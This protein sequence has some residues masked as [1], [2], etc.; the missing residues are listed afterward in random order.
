MSEGFSS[1][2]R[3]GVAEPQP[4]PKTLDAEEERKRRIRGKKNNFN[5]EEPEKKNLR[6]QEAAW[7][8]CAKDEELEDQCYGDRKKRARILTARFLSRWGVL[9]NHPDQP[10]A[11]QSEQYKSR[12]QKLTHRN[13]VEH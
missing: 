1:Q 7:K 11:I 4:K 8:I 2:R 6:T 13:V 9:Q 5:A 12:I 10:Q 3:H